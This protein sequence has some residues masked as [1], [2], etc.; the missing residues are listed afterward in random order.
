M[1]LLLQLMSVWGRECN[2]QGMRNLF[3]LVNRSPCQSCFNGQK[4]YLH[5]L[6]QLPTVPS[7]ARSLKYLKIIKFSSNRVSLSSKAFPAFTIFR[8]KKTFV[9]RIHPHAKYRLNNST[10]TFRFLLHLSISFESD[11]LANAFIA[12]CKL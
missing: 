7:I 6:L 2:S 5:Q 12:F 8:K 4:P 9:L 11:L 1:K 3:R 10:V